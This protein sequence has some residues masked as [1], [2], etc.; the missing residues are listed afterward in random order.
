MKIVTVFLIFLFACVMMAGAEEN[1]LRLDFEEG[2]T[3]QYQL[4]QE[5]DL[6]Q[7]VMGQE[8]ATTILSE[9]GLAMTIEK[10][11][12]PDEAVIAMQYTYMT[13][14]M[15]SNGNILSYDSRQPEEDSMGIFEGWTQIM[16]KDIR[17]TMDSRGNVIDYEGIEDIMDMYF[18]SEENTRFTEMFDMKEIMQQSWLFYPENPVSIGDTWTEQIGLELPFSLVT[19]AIYS[20]EKQDESNN[21]LGVNGSISLMTDQDKM[22]VEGMEMKLNFEG[23]M[24]QKIRTDR[25]S[26][27]LNHSE[28]N[29]FI[30][31]EMVMEIPYEEELTEIKMPMQISTRAVMKKTQ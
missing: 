4:S 9:I 12:S 23:T 7:T 28:G 29:S 26:G 8:V 25:Q 14:D 2:R 27:W 1:L 20:F 31:G 16:D 6:V 5:Q 18:D 10:V 13:I 19:E 3:F 21:Y 17:I 30:E 11:S 24:E 22:T 15:E